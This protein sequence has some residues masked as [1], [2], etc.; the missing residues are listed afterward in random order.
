[1]KPK[2]AENIIVGIQTDFNFE[3]FVTEKEDWILDIEKYFNSRSSSGFTLD[4]EFILACR[5]GISIIDVSTI[6][7]YIGNS[8]SDY[9]VSKDQLREQLIQSTTRQ[10]ILSMVPSLY[11]DFIE[12]KLY[13]LYPEFFSFEEYIPDGWQGTFEEFLDVIDDE[14]KYW[15]FNKKDLLQEKLNNLEEKNV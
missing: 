11:I 12:K 13:S 3:W 7:E 5:G 14:V 4:Q 15:I 8:M 1:M 2:Y 6:D 10:E 9:R